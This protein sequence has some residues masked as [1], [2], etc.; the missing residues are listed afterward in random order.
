MKA[1]VSSKGQVTIPIDIR[2]KTKIS[3]GSILDFHMEG[4]KIII[5][6]LAN[7]GVSE[8]KGFVKRKRRKPVSLTEMKKSI[9]KG[10]KESMK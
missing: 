1:T 7:R 6:P 2:S 9:L 4:D 3:T 10:A 8:L 5:I